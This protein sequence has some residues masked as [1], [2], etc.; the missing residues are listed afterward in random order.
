[1]ELKYSEHQPGYVRAL[2]VGVRDSTSPLDSRKKFLP[3]SEAL[4][5]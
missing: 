4:L 1:M 2:L 5:V 3:I